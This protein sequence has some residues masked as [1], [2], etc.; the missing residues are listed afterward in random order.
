MAPVAKLA[1]AH[2]ASLLPLQMVR[3]VWRQLRLRLLHR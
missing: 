2:T 3:Q 1:A